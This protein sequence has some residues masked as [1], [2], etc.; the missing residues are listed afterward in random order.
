MPGRSLVLLPALL[1]NTPELALKYPRNG[2]MIMRAPLILLLGFALV[3]TGCTPAKPPEPSQTMK[4]TFAKCTWEKVEGQ[5]L[6]IWSYACPAEA[7]D[8][9]LIASDKVGGFSLLS[10]GSDVQAYDVIRTFPKAKDAAL[11]SVLPAVLAATGV[12]QASC[13]L[14][15]TAYGDWGEVWLLEPTG[16]EKAAY[17][18]ANAIEPPANPCGELGIGPSGDRFFKVMGDDPKKVIYYDM[19]SEIQ[20]FDP[21]TLKSK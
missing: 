13:A 8:I 4:E 16:A 20:I 14:V 5:S 11:E 2:E 19:G 21:A 12:H 18:A 15:K 9:K 7:G 3:A 17:D 1:D 6:S 10:T